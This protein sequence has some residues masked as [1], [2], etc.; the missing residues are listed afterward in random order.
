MLERKGRVLICQRPPD[1]PFPLRWEF[2]GGKVEPGEDRRQALD[3]ELREELGVES[4]DGDEVF[5]TEHR[6][7]GGPHVDLAVFRVDSFEGDP[8]NL[9]FAAI[10]WVKPGKLDSFEF[11]AADRALVR[12]LTDGG[13]EKVGP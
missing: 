3:R 8:R 7:P 10:C 1:R 11:L 6:Y 13:E 5:R 12:W 4:S 2:P 9:A